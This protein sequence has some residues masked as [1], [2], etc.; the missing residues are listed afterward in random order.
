[1]IGDDWAN[2]WALLLL[3][4]IDCLML[5]VQFGRSGSLTYSMFS[6]LGL[7]LR[8]KVS[9]SSETFAYPLRRAVSYMTRARKQNPGFSKVAQAT[10]A[11]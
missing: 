7:T 5:K 3:G 9:A 4:T 10:F 1:M 6:A 2:D 8:C 11:K